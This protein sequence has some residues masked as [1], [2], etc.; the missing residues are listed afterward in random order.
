MPHVRGR[1]NSLPLL[2]FAK[3]FRV[4]HRVKSCSPVSSGLSSLCVP[5]P[6]LGNEDIS[7]KEDSYPIELEL[8]QD[9]IHPHNDLGVRES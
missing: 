4:S 5:R 6:W 1:E 9:G 8:F 7:M 3:V 2:L